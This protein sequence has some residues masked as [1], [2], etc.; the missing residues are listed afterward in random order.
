MLMPS[1]TILLESESPPRMK[2]EVSAPSCPV[3]VT[4]VPGISRMELTKSSRKAR[5]AG[6]STLIDA[7]VCGCGVGVPVAVINFT[8]GNVP[9]KIFHVNAV[10]FAA[11]GRAGEQLPSAQQAELAAE[12][13]RKK[14]K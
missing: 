1:R 13:D 8:V 4:N 5:S 7:L 3:C 9:W 14:Q 12:L 10:Y 11:F 6:P 2:S